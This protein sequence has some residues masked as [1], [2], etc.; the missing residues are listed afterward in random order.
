MEAIAFLEI[1]GRDG[2]VLARH[3]VAEF[4]YRVG[5]AYDNH[6]ILD[7]PYVA[8]HHLEIAEVLPGR[9]SLC[10]LGS[11]NGTIL[12]PARRAVVSAEVGPDEIV[13]IGHTQLRVRPRGFSVPLEEDLR[14]RDWAKLPAVCVV[15]SVTA[16][17]AIAG[18][19]YQSSGEAIAAS[20][21][22]GVLFVAIGAV[23][24]WS[25]GWA[26]ASRLVTS[27]WS[28]LAHITVAGVA[29]LAFMSVDE[30]V[31]ALAFA[32]G[33]ARLREWDLLL[34]AGVFA[35]QCYRHL[36][37]VSRSHRRRLAAVGLAVS[38][39]CF[40]GPTLLRWL[41]VRDNPN[42]MAYLTDIRP[43][44]WRLASGVTPEKFVTRAET[45]R[46]RVDE[47]QRAH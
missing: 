35:F 33:W 42:K 41:A 29:I 37:L 12:F 13:R 15:A 34:T 16:V 28:Y 8:A 43:P 36:R 32:F 9:Y 23:L 7:D 1:L 5:R 30:V 6:A 18:A 25:A 17:A 44:T 46:L 4:P 11:R 22:L 27:Q 38:L 21:L 24:V 31:G 39:V 47:N 14:K 20:S 2:R 10:D 40:G 19:H 26:F 3:P 45:L